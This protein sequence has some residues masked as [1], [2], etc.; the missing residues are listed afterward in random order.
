[1]LEVHSEIKEC[2]FGRSME[3]GEKGIDVSSKNNLTEV[4]MD[5]GMNLMTVG[6]NYSEFWAMNTVEMHQVF[7]SLVVKIKTDTDRRLSEYHSLASMVGAAV[8]GKLPKDAPVMEL[9]DKALEGEDDTEFIRNYGNLM[10]L[11]AKYG[12]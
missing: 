6:V 10:K 8:W 3:D 7:N 2:L 11:A 5:I 12:G 4:F 9:K 1:M